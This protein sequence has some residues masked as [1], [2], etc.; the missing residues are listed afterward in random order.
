MV[1]QLPL[2]LFIFIISLVAV[3]FFIP[4]CTGEQDIKPVLLVFFLVCVFL[5]SFFSW[6]K[7][8]IFLLYWIVIVGGVRKWIFPELADYLFFSPHLIVFGVYVK[9]FGQKI[10]GTKKSFSVKPIFIFLTLLVF[11]GAISFFN[12]RMA[13]IAIWALGMITHFYFVPLIFIVPELFSSKDELVA[14]LK[15]YLFFALP[16]FM[17]GIV[18][19]YSPA[20]SFINQYVDDSLPIAMAGSHARISATFSYIGGYT[21][22]LVLNALLLVCLITVTKSAKTTALYIFLAVLLILNI[23]MS[24]SRGAIGISVVTVFLYIVISSRIGAQIIFG[25]MMFV[26][27]TISVILAVTYTTRESFESFSERGHEDVGER[28]VKTMNSLTLAEDAGVFGYGIGATYQGAKR[29]DID[30]SNILKNE[31]EEEPIRILLE[32]GLVGYFLVYFTRLLFLIYLARLFTRLKDVDLRLI[33]L[34]V[35]CFQ[36][37]FLHFNNMTFVVTST[38]YYWFFSGFIFL[39]P[40]LDESG[41]KMVKA[42]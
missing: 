13:H 8:T 10:I 2:L 19:Y 14:F 33:A 17:L 39:L 34:F 9:F 41:I 20:D 23:L 35:F 29:L 30:E 1:K 12:P 7:A 3:Y 11:W 18:Q 36:L 6:K 5:F 37:Q 40:M 38:I 32:L 25:K 31:R 27:L 22:Y 21:P 24:G 28:L 15:K 16:L 4:A 26:I 42:K